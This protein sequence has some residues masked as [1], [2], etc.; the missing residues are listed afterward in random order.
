MCNR[1]WS[2]VEDVDAA[3]VTTSRLEGIM[4]GQ[5]DGTGKTWGRILTIGLH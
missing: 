4:Q 1:F 5:G 2:E 3:R